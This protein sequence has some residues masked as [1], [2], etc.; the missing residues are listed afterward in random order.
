MITERFTRKLCVRCGAVLLAVTLLCSCAQVTG[1]GQVKSSVDT[2]VAPTSIALPPPEVASNLEAI[3]VPSVEIF[4]TAL[5]PVVDEYCDLMTSGEG[6]ELTIQ[7]ISGRP[8]DAL[9]SSGI[10]ININDPDDYYDMTGLRISD[11]NNPAL[12][13]RFKNLGKKG[14]TEI[15]IFSEVTPAQ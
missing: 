14:P 8:L 6:P 12:A 9:D 4:P 1:Q 15:C 11:L 2:E 3:S 13:P 7:R 5:T 10:S